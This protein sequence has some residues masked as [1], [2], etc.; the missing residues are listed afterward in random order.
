LP[1]AGDFA[2]REN[3][4]YIAKEAEKKGLDSVW[5]FERLLWPLKPK[6]PYAGT[7]D[8]SLP[9]EYQNVL[10]SLETLSYLAGHTD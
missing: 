9:V 10:D 2:T 4:L 1:Q 6:T 5:V 8:G 7:P 3:V